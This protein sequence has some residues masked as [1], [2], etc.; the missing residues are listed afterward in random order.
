MAPVT[1]DSV[2]GVGWNYTK[3]I[4]VFKASYRATELARTL[5]QVLSLVHSVYSPLGL[6]APLITEG[7][8]I[9]QQIMKLDLKW[10]EELPDWL[11]TVVEAWRLDLFQMEKFTI[12]PASTPSTSNYV[13]HIKRYL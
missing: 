5:R 8:L 1:V 12:N 9:L 13:I 10:D 6:L 7:K 11:L 4:F 3:D 2:L